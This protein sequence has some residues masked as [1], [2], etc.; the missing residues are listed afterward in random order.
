MK[1]VTKTNVKSMV[2]KKRE[3]QQPEEV[4]RLSEVEKA[5]ELFRR[6]NRSYPDDYE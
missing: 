2:S 6:A 3:F 4:W 5:C 1:K